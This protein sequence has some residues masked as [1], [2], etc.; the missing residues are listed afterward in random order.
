MARENLGG[1]GGSSS[2]GG[3]GNTGKNKSPAKAKPHGGGKGASG[4]RARAAWA[5]RATRK[6]KANVI[7]V[8]YK[9]TGRKSVAR[10]FVNKSR[11]GDKSRPI[12][13]VQEMS[14]SRAC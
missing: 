4:A 8:V 7:T 12:S 13:Y 14:M 6:R 2:G 11:R 10:G 1:G 9:A 5:A 3:S